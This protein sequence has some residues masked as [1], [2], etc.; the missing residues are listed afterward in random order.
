MG[1]ANEILDAIEIMV[2][3]V[4]EDNTTKIYTG[5]C[6]TVST[7]TCSLLINGKENTVKYYGGTPIVGTVY[8]VFI[9]FG[10]MS[11]AFIIVPGAG[12]QDPE[13]SVSSVNGKTGAVV[14]TA[15]DVGA[16]PNTTTIPTKTSQLDNDSG[17][18]DS[19]ALDEYAK[20]ADIPT[21][22][23]QLTNNSGF[24]TANDV[25]VQSVD[26]LIGA[27]VTNAVKTTP[28][29][30]TDIQKAQARTNIG[31]GTSS[32]DGNYENL[33]N[34]PTIPTQ[35]SQLENNSGFITSADVPTKVSQ[36]NNDT[37]FITSND[38]P[39][40]SVIKATDTTDY[41]AVYYLTKNGVN[42]G[43]AI[44]IPKDLFVENGEIVTNP[45]GQPVGKY[46]KLVLQNQAE[47]I[48]INVADLVDAYTSGIGISI[49]T[50]NE[51]SI[52]IV[53]GNGLSADTDGIKMAT[54]TATTNGAMLSGDKAKLDGIEN[55]A[56]KNTVTG[57]KGDNEATYRVGNV[58]I[59]KANIGLN[60]VDNVKQYSLSNPPPYPVSSVNNKTGA[61]S[62]DA[63]DVGAV[64]TSNITQT[65]GTST[66]KVP[67][68]KAVSD[69]LS[70]AGAGDMLKAIYDPNG[71]VATAGG[72]PNYVEANGGKIDTIK[73]NGATQ[74]ITNKEVDITVPTNNNQLTNGAGYITASEAPVTSV[75]GQTG[76]VTV[77]TELPEHLVK[78][79][80]LA[81]IETTTPINADTL[82]GHAANYFA[83][84]AE[85]SALSAVVDSNTDDITANA[86]NISTNTQNISTLQSNISTL[87][88]SVNG[89]VS[90][91]GGTMTGV[92]VAKNNTNYS[93]AQVRN[94]IISTSDPSGGN[95]GDIWIKY[96]P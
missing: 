82:Q 10:N 35:T 88:S 22:T 71:S 5:V 49:S 48:Y 42:T 29:S 46:L 28:Q 77:S 64:S 60:N 32:F 79:D 34:K 95:S 37:G 18:I 17:F 6:K 7:S 25:P 39:E 56:Q 2:R 94:I 80:T 44:N 33:S 9:P 15:S 11:A 16:L 63:S 84:G 54:V 8:Q 59:T 19:N 93:V 65:L 43:V 78:Y 73:V 1:F 36:L 20:T 14:L 89:K 41:A 45:S 87:Q 74:P 51:I 13:T 31:A 23:S 81:P 85:V 3:Q 12:G 57:I 21:K 55:G 58:N 70:G 24:I 92:L 86:Q 62:L 52:K 91:S 50:N 83:T 76:D 47:P 27:V 40:Y 53:V 67:S 90:K 4:V 68:E 66:T 30:L 72:I 26:G 75:N 96:T 38:V 61:V 69:A